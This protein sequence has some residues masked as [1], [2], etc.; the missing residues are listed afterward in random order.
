MAPTCR[1]ATLIV[2]L[3][4]SIALLLVY[5]LDMAVIQPFLGQPSQQTQPWQ[6]T[7]ADKIEADMGKIPP[8]WILDPDVVAAAKDRRKIAGEFVESLLDNDTLRIT[9]MDVIQLVND[10]GAAQLSAVQ[11]VTAFSKRAAFAHQLVSTPLLETISLH[12]STRL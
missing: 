10:M 7:V 8:Q 11:V 3:Y 1:A 9:S 5:I 12:F 4:A 2:F 6:K